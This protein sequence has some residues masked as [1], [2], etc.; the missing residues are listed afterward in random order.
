MLFI[1]PADIDCLVYNSS[2]FHS[3][4]SQKLLILLSF[5]ILPTKIEDD[6]RGMAREKERER[7]EDLSLASP[8]VTQSSIKVLPLA[9]I[10]HEI[11]TGTTTTTTNPITKLN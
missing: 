5:L 3:V 4:S 7:E 6:R 11:V 8:T 2:V 9:A 10:N 1:T